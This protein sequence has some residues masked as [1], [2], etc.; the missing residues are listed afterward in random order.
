LLESYEAERRPIGVRNI[1][2]ARTNMAGSRGLPL[3][4]DIDADTPSG[5]ESRRKL[6]EVLLARHP[7]RVEINPG[8]ELGY[9][10]AGSPIVW[11]DG[12]PE[13][14][15]EVSTY[16][17][18]TWPGARAPH[19]WLADGR[20]TLDAFGRGFVLVSFGAIEAAGAIADAARARGAPLEIIEG[21]PAAAPL[22]ER[23]L[24][25]VRPD[26]HVAWRGN[27]PPDDALA[28]IDRVRGA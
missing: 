13:P 5:E 27:A 7:E 25:L 9:R 20:S 12:T 24:V 11:P 6:R 17:Q 8:V 2:A 22:Y 23:R 19:A 1:E 26:G 10:Y 16:T 4:D 3:P 15:E 18:T 21:A 28:M 14:A